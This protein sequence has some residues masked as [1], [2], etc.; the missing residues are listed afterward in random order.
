MNPI[1]LTG[2]EPFGGSKVNPSIE[3]CKPHKGKIFNG[4]R[5]EV[6]E[7][8]LRFQEIRPTIVG[9]LDRLKP[10][11]VISTGQSGGE[12]I[13]LERVAINLADARIPYNCGAKPVD[14]PIEPGGPAAYFSTLPLRAI[15]KALQEE[16]IPS[17]LSNSAGTF[18]C[19]HLF[20]ELMYALD[21]RGWEIPAGFIHVPKLPSQAVAKPGPSMDL[22]LTTRALEVVLRV[23][24]E[25][26]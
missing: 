16:G 23:V 5:V 2:F 19:N 15:H 7:V 22:P 24:G 4:H 1:L 14:T 21:Q 8:P 10:A 25:T 3:A 6:V 13:A 26:L 11:A 20:Y 17:K 12:A 18:G 9:A